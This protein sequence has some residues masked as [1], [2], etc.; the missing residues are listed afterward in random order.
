MLTIGTLSV[1]SP[2]FRFPVAPGIEPLHP[3]ELDPE[4]Q[5][6]AVLLS[7][8]IFDGVAE[9]ALP[10]DRGKIVSEGGP[11]VPSVISFSYGR[12]DLPDSGL[13]L[14][15]V[16][17]S[18]LYGNYTVVPIARIA[19]ISSGI[20]KVSF[21]SDSVDPEHPAVSIE[22]SPKKSSSTSRRGWAHAIVTVPDAGAIH[23]RQRFYSVQGHHRRRGANMEDATVRLMQSLNL[24][25]AGA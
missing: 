1:G 4:K 15:G 9:R 18:K 2:E 6:R 11:D 3:C 10:D 16:D 22:T 14:M 25:S 5:S 17:I 23:Q 19:V 8:V 20:G 24:P 21:I 12:A 13:N 7:H